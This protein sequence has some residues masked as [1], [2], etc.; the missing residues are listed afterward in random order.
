VCIAIRPRYLVSANEGG[1]SNFGIHAVTVVPFTAAFVAAAALLFAAARTSAPRSGLDRR[2]G[3]ALRA[4]SAVLV[5]VLVSTYDYKAAVWLHDLHVDVAIAATLYE[6]ALAVGVVAAVTRDS[7]DL[8]A[9]GVQLAGLALAAC[10]LAGWLH[11]LLVAQLVGSAG[12]AVLVI[13][14]TAALAGRA[15]AGAGGR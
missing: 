7:A 14:A 13:R 10:S 2:F 15:Q 1:I 8:A 3:T 11:V 4:L 6:S 5:V 9:L 12:F